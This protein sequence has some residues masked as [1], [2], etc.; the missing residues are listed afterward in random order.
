MSRIRILKNLIILCLV[1]FTLHFLSI[2]GESSEHSQHRRR[3]RHRVP[4]YHLRF[5]DH[6][7]VT[8]SQ[9][10]HKKT[11]LQ[12][13][14]GPEHSHL[15]PLHRS[16]LLPLHVNTGADHRS[17][18]TRSCTPVVRQVHLPER[19]QRPVRGPNIRDS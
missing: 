17:N 7:F 11:R 12:M 4:K 10:H 19:D 2:P 18:R 14:A 1:F 15:H 9:T 5:P 13:D 8:S 16:Q 6:L 3:H